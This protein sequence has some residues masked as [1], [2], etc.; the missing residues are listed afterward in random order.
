[1]S[2]ATAISLEIDQRVQ[3]R[4]D[5]RK[6]VQLA[7]DYFVSQRAEGPPT[8]TPS[9]VTISWG[10]SILDGEE[11]VVPTVTEREENGTVRSSRRF[12]P[13]RHMSDSINRDIWMLRLWRG[14]L[15][16]RSAENAKRIEAILQRMD[17]EESTDGSQVTD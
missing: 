2:V 5:L 15:A 11:V 8:R 9:T 7:S 17:E 4:E 10:L 1:M 3:S 13:T 14:T 12:I 16:A 6:S